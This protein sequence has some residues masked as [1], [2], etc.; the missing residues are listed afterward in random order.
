M[1]LQLISLPLNTLHNSVAHVNYMYEKMIQSYTYKI[2]ETIKY[3]RIVHTYV[4][5]VSLFHKD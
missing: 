3:L 4:A 2:K 1:Y 5:I